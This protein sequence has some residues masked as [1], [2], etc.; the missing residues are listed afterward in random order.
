MSEQGTIAK[1]DRVRVQVQN[2]VLKAYPNPGRKGCSAPSVAEYARKATDF[3]AVEADPE[4]QHIMHCSPCYA[5]FL[6]AREELRA[7]RVEPDS[8]KRLPR[9]MVKQM[10]KALTVLEKILN[11]G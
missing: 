8:G 10:D 11:E 5:E 9:K 4:Y 1:Y 6:A 3:K 7:Q 2:L